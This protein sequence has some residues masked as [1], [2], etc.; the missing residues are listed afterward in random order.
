M[1]RIVLLSVSSVGVWAGGYAIPENSLNSV[2]LGAAYVANAHGADAAYYNPAAM[3]FNEDA[4]QLE[5]AATYIGLTPIHYTSGAIGIDSKPESFVVPTFHFAS[6]K[7]GESGARVGLS[8]V[9]PVGLS[10]RWNNPPAVYTAQEFTLQTVEINPSM[11]VSLSDTLAFG[12]GFRVIRTDGTVRA[13]RTGIYSETMDG[14]ATDYGYNLALNYRPTSSSS[15]ALTYRSKV[16]LDVDGDA[17]LSFAGNPSL[18]VPAFSGNYGA[19]VSVPVPATLNLAAA[20]SFDTG[21]TLELVY[22]RTYWSAYETLD[23]AFNHPLAEAVFGSPKAKHWHDT[24]SFRLGLTQKADHW[25]IMGGIAY[26]ESPIPNDTLSFEL[27]DS[28]AWI[29]STGFRYQVDDHWDVGLAGL[30]DFKKDRS[31]SNSFV[32]TGEFSDAKAYL[33]T[34]GIGYR[35]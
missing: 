11:A 21:T 22:G 30:I 3:V 6:K 29:V 15:L 8:V 34:C 18:G 14:S 19:G 10:K 20:Y 31:L 13:S 2:A 28:D 9:T 27:P 17:S 24:D 26:D 35:F 16:D 23:F 32:G 7:L 25:T 12:A 5:L 33:V 1:K 4:N